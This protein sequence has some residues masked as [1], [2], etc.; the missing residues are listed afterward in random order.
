MLNFF[1]SLIRF[2]PALIS[3]AITFVSLFSV[4]TPRLEADINSQIE[5]IAV[6]EKAYANGE[7]APVDEESF[8]AG[9][10]NA[11][12]ESGIKFN[13]MR[14]TATHNSYQSEA[15]DATKKL[16]RNLSTV[17]FGLIPEDKA[18]FKSETLTE[19]FNNG[20]RSIEMD[21]ETF[22]RNGEISFT[23]MHSPYIE[24]TTTC[25][26]FSLAMKEIAMWS[27]NN[28]NHLPITV[29]IEPKSVIFALDDMKG[30]SYDYALELDSVLKETLG[31]KLFTPADMLRDYESFGE[32]RANDDWCE[33]KN[34]LGKVLILLHDCGVTQNYIDA[35]PSLKT[36]AMF[37]MLRENDAEKDYASF[38]LS[39][40]PSKL[41][42]SQDYIIDEKK[43]IV[44][45]RAD[46][47]GSISESKAENALNSNAHIVST[48]YPPRTDNTADSYVFS[49]GNKKTISKTS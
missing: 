34:M 39:N 22:D 12:L 38:I 37:P 42:K 18:E 7:I 27:D 1:N 44:R 19:Q 29:I 14:F 28:P 40:N 15:T 10:L 45:T 6:L 23:C 43:L 47:F 26:D 32:M 2:L 16:Y 46:S 49:F 35:D 5:R 48:D 21:V 9:D 8:F 20:V 24:M 11:E 30:F 36:Q 3:T 33:V 25:Y 41:L 31:D 17:T 4:N 13:E